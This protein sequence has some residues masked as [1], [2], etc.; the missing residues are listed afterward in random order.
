MVDYTPP[1]TMPPIFNPFE[2]GIGLDEGLVQT[3]SNLNGI[4][5]ELDVI[6]A[7]VS[8]IGIVYNIP[9]AVLQTTTTNIQFTQYTLN[10][11][12][13]TY[14]IKYSVMAN[15]VSTGITEISAVLALDGVNT[16]SNTGNCSTYVFNSIT[17]LGMIISAND[18][19]LTCK[20]QVRTTSSASNIAVT[21]NNPTYFPYLS[22]ANGSGYGSPLSIMRIK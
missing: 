1:R 20:C 14:M 18:F 10:L 15:V 3:T 12:A 13:G 8:N 19:V 21:L 17:T 6:S 22:T 11:S 4:I 16:Q 5:E 7:E 2:F 9:T